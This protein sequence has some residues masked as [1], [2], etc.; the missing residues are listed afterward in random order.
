MK[1]QRKDEWVGSEIDDNFV[2]VHI[3][4]GKYIALNATACAV[5][6]ALEEERDADEITTFLCER[7]DVA[8]DQCRASVDKLLGEMQDMQLVAAS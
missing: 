5:W 7:F 4:S 6:D 3:E 1:W 8:P 2:M